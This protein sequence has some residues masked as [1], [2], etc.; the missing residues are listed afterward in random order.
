VRGQESKR[1]AATGW[2][3][4]EAGKL[5]LCGSKDFIFLSFQSTD[6]LS[7]E[8]FIRL[9]ANYIIYLNLLHFSFSPRTLAEH[10]NIAKN[11]WRFFLT[12]ILYQPV[13]LAPS[14][15]SILP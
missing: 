9:V 11:E 7:P 14:Q 15:N 8:R 4:G 1:L 12:A 5:L 6:K 3:K 2:L 13:R 10:Y